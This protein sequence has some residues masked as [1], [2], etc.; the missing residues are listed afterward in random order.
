[1]LV[2]AGLA[3]TNEAR[4]S[5]K[6]TETEWDAGVPI[7]LARSEMPAAVI[8][9]QIYVAGGFYEGSRADRFDTATHVWTQ[10]PDLPIGVHHPAVTAH[11]GNFYVAGGYAPDDHSA[12][13]NLWA[14]S[15]ATNEW[16]LLAPLPDAKG[17]MGLVALEGA[18]YAV[19]GAFQHLG[20]AVSDQLLRYDVALNA[21]EELAPM[22]TGREHLAVVT[23]GS[24]IYAIGGRADG[25]EAT[26]YGG[27]NEVFDP[28]T[29]LWSKLDDLP[30]ARSGLAGVAAGESVIVIGGERGRSIYND[31]NRYNT[32]TGKWDVLPHLGTA[33]HG[34][35][36]A[37]VNGTLYA[38]AGSTLAG[39]VQNVAIVET[40]ALDE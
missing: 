11:D 1:V 25:N 17:A 13:D 34:L 27:A 37:F 16:H 22:P 21:W 8:D 6:T 4:Q 40:L 35:A 32:V 28:A 12:V 33:R 7:P 18:L 3:I 2:V 23:T 30:V 9:G 5:A 26:K 15:P 10:L 39:S 38:I 36:A 14:F 24:K 29:G 20:G 31:V 19:G